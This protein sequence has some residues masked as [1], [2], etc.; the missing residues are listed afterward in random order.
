MLEKPVHYLRHSHTKNLQALFDTIAFA[1]FFSPPILSNIVY[2][3]YFINAL[4]LVLFIA[5]AMIPLM[6]REMEFT[7]TEILLFLFVGWGLFV[8]LINA[9]DYLY[10]YAAGVAFKIV[11]MVFLVKNAIG[12][13]LTKT[14]H[15][16]AYYFIILIWANA[17]LM[18]MYPKGIMRSSIGAV[19]ERACWLFGSKN[20]VT[21]YAILAFL[22]L[23]LDSIRN[24][25]LLNW[26]TIAVFMV[27]VICM[28]SNEV[29][30]MEGS[31]TALFVTVLF[32][33]ATV[34]HGRRKL[35]P[36]ERMFTMTQIT[37]FSIILCVLIWYI[38][39]HGKELLN[40]ILNDV[41]EKFGKDTTFSSR[42][43]IWSN[44]FHAILERPVLGYGFKDFYFWGDGRASSVYSFW[45]STLLYYG[46]PGTIILIAAFLK[47][48]NTKNIRRTHNGETLRF[49][50]RCGFFLL[51][52]CGLVNV[53]E[54][55]FLI[56][57]IELC[58]YSEKLML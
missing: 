40:G 23:Y 13:D 12:R 5:M 6:K 26:M 39:W 48:D 54:W 19:T 11:A 28:G 53:I 29:Q 34:L 25:K 32:A 3:D 33:I 7:I 42:D 37:I 45:G 58:N 27:E 17:L 2:L 24:E 43:I 47:C 35:A 30:F 36:I 50:S 44:T 4:R 14:I 57:L 52:I 51:M 46:L 10:Q 49:V 31:T 56:L 21:V 9:T 38:S 8:M 18:I 16:I 55:H 1:A 20:Q 15:G 41:L 22:F